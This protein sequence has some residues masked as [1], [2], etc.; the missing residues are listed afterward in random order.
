MRVSIQMM[1]VHFV[2]KHLKLQQSEIA[3]DA[4]ATL[5]PPSSS[6]PQRRPPG[7]LGALSSQ[8]FLS[9]L[10]TYLHMY[11]DVRSSACEGF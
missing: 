7:H 10:H 5:Q 9:H 2:V 3:S 6:L 4:P 1:Q 11:E 8:L